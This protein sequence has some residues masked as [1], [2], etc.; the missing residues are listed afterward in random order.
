M[1]QESFHAEKFD[2]SEKSN[3]QNVKLTWMIRKIVR[4]FSVSPEISRMETLMETRG[5]KSIFSPLD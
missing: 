3:L 4:Y 2:S 5:K 1:I